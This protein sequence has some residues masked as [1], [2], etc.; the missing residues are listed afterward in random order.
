MTEPQFVVLAHLED[1][2]AVRVAASLAHRNGAAAVKLVSADELVM[3]RR[4][5]HAITD[6]RVS[7]KVELADGTAL[8][9]GRSSVIFNR[10]RAIPLPRVHMKVSDQE[11]AVMEFHALVLSWLHGLECRVVNR[12][13]ARGLSG[14]ERSQSEWLT[15]AAKAGLPVR[16]RAFVTDPRRFPRSRMAAWDPSGEPA[17]IPLRQPVCYLEQP[18]SDM[19]SVVVAGQRFSGE[20]APDTAAALHR[21]GQMSE[22]DLLQ[23]HFARFG[24]NGTEGWKVAEVTSFP[25][26]ASAAEVLA[27]VRLLEGCVTKRQVAQ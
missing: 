2:T 1:D 21:L 3:A 5:T 23:V 14:A 20:V 10:L 18:F 8:E 24:S 15:L 11:Y 22:C 4:W 13:S 19:E 9:P 25:D 6:S 16:D 7:S 26:T 27:I 17:A 12:P